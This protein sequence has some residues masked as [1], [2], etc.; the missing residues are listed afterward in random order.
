[1]DNQLVEAMKQASIDA[2]PYEG[3]GLIVTSGNK[4][5]LIVCPN[6]SADPRNQFLIGVEGYAKAAEEGEVVAVWHSHVEIANTPSEADKHGCEL[7]QMPWFITAVKKTDDGFE[8]SYPN[9]IEPSGYE[10]PYEGRP[11]VFGVFDCWALIRDYY[12]REFGVDLEDFNRV[13]FFWQK[14]IDVIG[15]NWENAGFKLVTDDSYQVGD[16]FLIQNSAA[17]MNHVALYIGNDQILHHC[18]N[19]LSRKDT[20]AGYW[21][22]HTVMHIRH[23]SKC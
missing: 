22:K 3:C 16:L 7:S 15:E 11:Y 10:A 17:M 6:Q 12:R 14:G 18:H 13:E 8:V 5:K 4:P 21:H 19:R 23:K 20:Y 1:M 2:Y 9:K